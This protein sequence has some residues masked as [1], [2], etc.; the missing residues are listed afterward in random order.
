MKKYFSSRMLSWQAKNSLA[1]A[2]CFFV[3][4]LFC[5]IVTAQTSTIT[6]LVT[7]ASGKPLS[8]VSITV[9]GTT[10]GTKSDGN[11]YYSISNIVSST[12]L[13]F[14]AVGMISQEVTI[15]NQ[16]T[17]NIVLDE[18][19]KELDEVVVIGYGAVK[20]TD[21]TGSVATYSGDKLLNK[22]SSP[23]I[24]NALQ[25]VMPGVTVTRS[26]GAPNSVGSIRV[27][28]TTTMSTNDPYVLIDG[29]PGSL[30]MIK[31]D[32]VESISVLKDAASAS[33]YGS[34]A[35]AGV[36]LVTTRRAKAGQLNLTYDYQSGI[37]RPT[38]LT[39]KAGAVTYMRMLNELKWNDN[40]NQGNEYN[41]YAQELI[42]DYP[43]LHA[44]DPDKYPDTDWNQYLKE[45]STRGSHA[46]NFSAGSKNI[47]TR[48][49][50]TYDNVE[51]IIK[52]R[53]YDNFST[54][55]NNDVT[56]NKMIS[57]HFDV[58]YFYYHD[59][60]K[61]AE[62]G[63]N[64]FVLEPL[65]RAYWTDG[66]VAYG[67]NSQNL[68]ANMEKGG[69][70]DTYEH[71]I[72]GKFSLDFEPI[73]GLKIQGI[74]APKFQFYQ[75]KNH[76]IAVPM[77]Y[78][79]DK[80]N[81]A[82]YVGG[83]NNTSV[84]EARNQNKEFTTQFL[85]NYMKTVGSHNLN[86][87]AGYEY[88]YF[89]R[90]T[91]G[92]SRSYYKLTNFPYL[93]LG[94]LDYRDNSGNGE[95]YASRSFFGRVMYS[96]KSKYLL[97]AN[98][99]YDGSSR[100]H[101]D[102][103]YGL[104]PSASIGWVLSKEA[105][106]K[107]LAPVVSFMKI[108]ASYGSLGNERIGSYYP[109]QSTVAFSNNIMYDGNTVAAHQNAYL[110]GLAIKDIT[111]ETTKSYDFGVDVN[112]FTN[113]L[114]FTA[115]YYKKTTTGMLLALQIPVFMGY[116]NPSVN[117]GDMHTKGWELGIQYNNNIKDLA[118]SVS[119]NLS[120]AKSIMGDLKGTE[121]LG[122]QVR[123]EGSEFN[124]WYGYKSNGLFQTDEDVAK[125]AKPN[126]NVRPGDVKYIDI[127]GPD[128]VPDGKISPEY[129][130]ALLGGSSPRYEYGGNINLEYKN[131]DLSWV[132]QGVAKRK[133]QLSP[134]VV[135]PL[136]DG[137]YS[138][139]S[140]IPDDY[141]SNYNTEEKN[142][143]VRYPRLSQIGAAGN[144]YIFSDYWLINGA[145]FRL[146]NII[147][148]YTVPQKVTK[149]IGIQSLRF[150]V[151]LSDY[152]TIDRFPKGWDPEQSID[153][154]YITKAIFFGASLKF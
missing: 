52:D 66:R 93:D 22:K 73:K 97:Q 77:Y 42:N 21:L 28:G 106:M 100:F 61:Q 113:K 138:I 110:G 34:K 102:Y 36:I 50:I 127:S 149:N 32:D 26:S 1:V 38:R 105:F 132:F 55:I 9:K 98:V 101:R 133:S 56:I 8:D 27:R 3:C 7:S 14:S 31:A 78:L 145:Y 89:F 44:E 45:H 67:R 40:G 139:P 136:N 148:G 12:T 58:N 112:F 62:P 70:I 81:I 16:T 59:Q 115:D 128:G 6:G 25:G 90:E 131:F 53:P 140:F 147:L 48:G 41:T 95:E 33:I 134:N 4:V 5:T 154:Y 124:E 92:A 143:I 91:L 130:R 94:P 69:T 116:P 111:W 114:Q 123:F 46:L 80:D 49:S 76:K 87:L 29:V 82:S 51:S 137:V 126:N 85:A 84:A 119:V 68:I 23:L 121:F 71:R 17:I 144:N 118:Y 60:P 141:W 24:V 99:R 57:V 19:N 18:S 150:Y 79:E 37:E 88:Y 65:L 120:D 122:S 20:K 74:F 153:S 96:F 2:L 151:N 146:K 109:Y 103:R 39:Q 83:V 15:G 10:L 64:M 43:K 13:V 47:S 108:R 72:A 142:K 125:S 86:F 75:Q 54:R 35:A 117:A 129:D 135:R 11:G 104:F 63:P 152:F 107:D 30:S